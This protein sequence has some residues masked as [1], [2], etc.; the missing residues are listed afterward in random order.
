MRAGFQRGGRGGAQTIKERNGGGM[1][2]TAKRCKETNTATR[3]DRGE[4]KKQKKERTKK[5]KERK[6]NKD[7]KK[8]T[9]KNRRK[10]KR[11]NRINLFLTHTLPQFV[12]REKKHINRRSIRKRRKKKHTTKR[13]LS[14]G[15]FDFFARI[16]PISR[17][18]AFSLL[19]R[20]E[21]PFFLPHPSPLP[22]CDTKR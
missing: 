21:P 19:F 3:N 10:S 14:S 11:R 6:K 20:K 8:K 15:T 1:T 22:P 9:H 18:V 4:I 17:Q 12:Q 2:V 16:F 7:R 5:R 13:I